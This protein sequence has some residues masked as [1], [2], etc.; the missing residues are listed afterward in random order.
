MKKGQLLKPVFDGKG[1][2]LHITLKDHSKNVHR[3]V[4]ETFIDNPNNYPEVNHKD[5]N[6]LNNRVDNLEWCTH[7]YN[8]TYGSRLGRYKGFNNPQAKLSEHCVR[9]IKSKCSTHRVSDLAKEY[10][11]SETHISAI[12]HG[13]RW[14][15]IK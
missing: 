7:N 10:G 14:G 12:K 1:N 6:K 3:L 15:W 13:R 4:A 9:E 11:I 5:E 8:S 2:Y